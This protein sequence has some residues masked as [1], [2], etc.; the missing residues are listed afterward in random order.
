MQQIVNMAVLFLISLIIL[1]S[2]EFDEIYYIIPNILKNDRI[3]LG[4]AF[5]C[6][7]VLNNFTILGERKNTKTNIIRSLYYYKS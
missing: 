4:G 5:T 6:E 3:K 2:N 1:K 7:Y